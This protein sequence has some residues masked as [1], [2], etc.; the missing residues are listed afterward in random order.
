M[1]RLN[2]LIAL[3]GRCSR[4]AADRLIAEG[5]VTVNGQPVT[6]L[7]SR[8]DRTRATIKVDG[9][10]LRIPDGART[11]LMLNK[12]RGY[13]TTLS[14]PEGRP[15]VSD[16]LKGIR[17]RVFPVGRL[18]FNS[19]GL[20]LF[21]D[22]GELARDLMHPRSG[23]PKTYAVKVRG[24]PAP[25]QLAR[26]ARGVRLDG[27]PTAPAAVR[28]TRPG[29]N[30]WLEIT[31]REGRKHQVRRM[32][33]VIGHRVLRL[34]RIGYDG[35]RLADLAPGALRELTP[36]EVRKL[37]RGSGSPDPRNPLKNR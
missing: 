15:T 29:P 12:P 35:L 36:A 1:E 10:R 27:K 26:L 19:E 2:K 8:V 37:R 13:V 23:V 33:D 21:T 20:L 3:S 6:T 28:L 24:R 11:F 34:R 30:S 5:R 7:G 4:R 9:K 17:G 16:F 22:D 31:V 32:V 25:E 14:D 18:D